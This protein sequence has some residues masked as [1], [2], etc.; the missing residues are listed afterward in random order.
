M[1]RS[2]FRHRADHLQR[3]IEPPALQRAH[4]GAVQARGLGQGLLAQAL[5]SCR[6][7]TT[8]PNLRCSRPSDTRGHARD[9]RQLDL[10]Q[11]SERTMR[12][13]RAGAAQPGGQTS[14]EQFFLWRW[15]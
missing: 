7:Q 2:P 13:P 15:F 14:A 5:G 8:R 6:R 3:G 10:R 12:K 11:L 4:V 9:P 1:E